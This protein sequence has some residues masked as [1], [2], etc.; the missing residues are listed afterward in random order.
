MCPKKECE[1]AFFE[2][3]WAE[4]K[5]KS[6]LPDEKVKKKTQTKSQINCFL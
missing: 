1:W 6:E 5:V 3:N 4:P 2:I